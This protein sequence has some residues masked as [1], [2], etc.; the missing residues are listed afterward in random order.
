M[1]D[2]G[3]VNLARPP[4]RIRETATFVVPTEIGGEQP[5][6]QVLLG[7]LP[8]G[9][10]YL[11]AMELPWGGHEREQDFASLAEACEVADGIYQLWPDVGTWRIERRGWQRPAAP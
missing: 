5:R 2:R 8:G 10:G 3:R 6:Y 7:E 9:R 11:Y 4:A 1:W